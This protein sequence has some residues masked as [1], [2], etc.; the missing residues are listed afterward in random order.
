[1]EKLIIEI[2]DESEAKFLTE[3]ISRLGFKIET[4]NDKLNQFIKNAPKNVPVT[5]KDIMDEINDV[6]KNQ[7]NK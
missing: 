6:R 2:P 1:M 7:N 3:I 4:I 5:D